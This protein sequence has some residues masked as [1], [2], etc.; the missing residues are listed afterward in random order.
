MITKKEF[1]C[2][3]L[4]V[5]GFYLFPVFVN[6]QNVGVGVLDPVEKLQV[7]GTVFA[8]SSGFRFPDGSLQTRAYNAYETQDAGDGRWII[9]MDIVNPAIPGSF[10]FDTLV[11]MIKVI[12]Y[13]WG[14]SIYAPIGGTAEFTVKNLKIIK[15][16]DASTN[17]LLEKT[18]T[19]QYLQ[20]V[21][22]YFFRP[23]PGQ[24]MK[25]YYELVMHD[26]LILAF[27]QKMAFIGGDQYIHLDIIEFEFAEALWIYY[28]EA[29]VAINQ[30]IYD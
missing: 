5:I 12:D 30:V 2:F 6:A 29:G 9:I 19:G 24:G 10:T 13:E 18:F 20:D 28:N 14:I 26:A 7:H 15:N 1:A 3:F 21:R 16:I 23:I 17:L 4:A 27:D 22:M 8:D 25:K 11:D